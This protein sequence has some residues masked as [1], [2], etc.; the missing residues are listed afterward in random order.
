MLLPSGE[1]ARVSRWSAIRCPGAWRRVRLHGSMRYSDHAGYRPSSCDRRYQS[2]IPGIQAFRHRGRRLV[3][4]ARGDAFVNAVF[5]RYGGAGR[6]GWPVGSHD[7]RPPMACPRSVGHDPDRGERGISRVRLHGAMRYSDHAGY[8]PSSCDRRYQSSIPG[9]QAF[10]HRG[11]R[12]VARARGDA[13]VNAVFRRY[14]GAGRRGWPVGSHDSRPPMACPRSVGHDPDR[15]ER[16]IS[17]VRLHGAMRYSDHAGYRPSSC[18]RRYQSSIAAFVQKEK[19]RCVS[20]G[21]LGVNPGDDLLS[22]GLSHTTIGA[23]AF[24]FRVRDGIGWFHSANFTRETV[25]AA[26]GRARSALVSVPHDQRSCATGRKTPLRKQRG[27]GCKPW[28]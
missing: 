27:F 28:R 26:R 7:S 6:R 3:A 14:G 5:R 24:H 10:R 25:G 9:I 13:F 16:G 8:R 18:D 21:V 12:L 1:S 4:R 19:P 15:G 22:H 23:A 17:R 20:S 2:S 11:R